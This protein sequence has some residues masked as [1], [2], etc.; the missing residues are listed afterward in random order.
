[1]G[2][3][4]WAKTACSGSLAPGFV[5]SSMQ[6]LRSLITLCM[7]ACWALLGL[8]TLCCWR[9]W[10]PPRKRR[11]YCC[12]MAVPISQPWEERVQLLLLWLLCQ[13]DEIR[14]NGSAIPTAPGV[15]FQLPHLC[16]VYHGFNE[17][18]AVRYSGTTGGKTG[19]SKTLTKC[20]IQKSSFTD[21]RTYIHKLKVK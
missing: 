8:N 17:Q 5:N 21:T 1:M 6:Q 20:C 19:I 18:C 12:V 11:H 15:F 7:Y 10:A 16:L 4:K 13:P 2:E 14:I 9:L 3:S